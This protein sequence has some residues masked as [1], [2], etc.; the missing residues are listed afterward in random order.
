[1]DGNTFSFFL[2]SLVLYPRLSERWS[3][4]NISWQSL[5]IVHNG[6]DPHGTPRCHQGFVQPWNVPNI[7][8]KDA[9]LREV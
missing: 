1:M 4:G 9:L 2:H 5:N 8:R 3:L 7:H 6:F